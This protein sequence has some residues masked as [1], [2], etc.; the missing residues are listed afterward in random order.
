MPMLSRHALIL[1]CQAALAA[2]GG[3]FASAPPPLP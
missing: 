3:D 2:L 1:S